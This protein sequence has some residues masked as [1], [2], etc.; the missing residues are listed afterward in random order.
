MK[1]LHSDID[2]ELLTCELQPGQPL[3]IKCKKRLTFEQMHALRDDLAI[4]VRRVLPDNPI[5]ITPPDMEI[6]DEA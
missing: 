6:S 5:I 3:F 1:L 4:H 2:L